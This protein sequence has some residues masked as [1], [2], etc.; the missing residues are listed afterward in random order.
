MSFQTPGY[1]LLLFLVPVAIYL[2]HVWRGRGGRVGFSFRSW[3]STGIAYRSVLLSVI[4]FLTALAFWCGVALLIISLAG[5]VSTIKHRVF[6]SRGVD[7]M[8]VLDESPSMFA[9]DLKTSVAG[10]GRAATGESRFQAAKQVISEFVKRRENDPVGL[11]SFAKDAVLQIPPTLDYAS[12]L[13]RLKDINPRTLG[14]GTAI[15]MGL[16]VA[17]LH[18]RS[19]DAPKKAIVLLTDGENNAGEVTPEQ[20]AQAAADFGIRIYAVGI[21]S[22]GEAPISYTDPETGKLYTGV[23]R[24]AF[25][26]DLLKNLAATTG[27]RYFNA[28]TSD[29]LSSVLRQ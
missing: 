25:D 7:I 28:S 13:A 16:G 3:A 9:A 24:G 22:T 5:P 14:N 11:V 2:R 18:L 17:V 21:G 4:R 20:A 6:L 23:L 15:G 12:F 10:G 26:E 8:F 19:S 27:G 1:L 29:G